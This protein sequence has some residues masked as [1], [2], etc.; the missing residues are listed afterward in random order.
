MATYFDSGQHHFGVFVERQRLFRFVVVVLRSAA[1][2]K[3]EEKIAVKQEIDDYFFDSYLSAV[4]AMLRDSRRTSMKRS[5]MMPNMRRARA[6]AH[7]WTSER[8]SVA[9]DGSGE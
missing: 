3:T 9:T 5:R 1:T 2:K 8:A 4:L 7:S 6:M